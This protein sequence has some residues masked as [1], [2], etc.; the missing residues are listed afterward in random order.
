MLRCYPNYKTLHR[1]FEKW[2]EQKVLRTFMTDLAN[3]LR[4]RGENWTSAGALSGLVLFQRERWR[5]GVGKASR[6]ARHL[7]EPHDDHP[8]YPVRHY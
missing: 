8:R 6:V 7:R 3:E 2:C 1:P 4:E 5:G